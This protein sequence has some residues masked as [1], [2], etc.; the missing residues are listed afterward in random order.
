[1]TRVSKQRQN[2]VAFSKPIKK[3][4]FSENDQIKV[5][6][7]ESRVSDKT[8]LSDENTSYNRMNFNYLYQMMADENGE[9]SFTRFM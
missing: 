2:H 6:T 3:V 1:M 7:K 5:F 8:D 4:S 9:L